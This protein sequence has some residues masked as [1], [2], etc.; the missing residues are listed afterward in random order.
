MYQLT[1][2]FTWFEFN[3]IVGRDSYTLTSLRIP[4][5]LGSSFKHLKRT[6]I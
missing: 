6:K 1:Q 5:L 3:N 4:P 2:I